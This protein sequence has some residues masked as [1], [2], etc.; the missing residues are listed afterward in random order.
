MADKAAARLRSVASDVPDHFDD[1]D[2]QL[3]LDYPELAELIRQQKEG[4]R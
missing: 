1:V 4:G 3:I 2:E